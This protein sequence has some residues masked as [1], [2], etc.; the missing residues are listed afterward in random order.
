LM[1][2]INKSALY[3]FKDGIGQLTDALVKDLR[4]RSNVELK[5]GSRVS[6]LKF[7]D[8]NEVEITTS[9]GKF[10]GD[11]VISTIPTYEL[12][13]LLPTLPHLEY[14]PF[15]TVGVVNVAY[16]QRNLLPIRGFGFLVPQ[17]TPNNHY[18]VL[19]I[20]FDSDAMP[21]QDHPNDN[22]TKVT[23]MLGGHYYDSLEEEEFPN[24]EELLCQALQ[25][26]EN[27]LGIY[28][29]PAEYVAK[30]QRKC[31]PQYYVNHHSRLKELHN[32]IKENFKN[33][34]SVCGSSYWGV[35]INDC[36]VNSARLALNL[37]EDKP[38]GVV[39]T[40]LERV[41]KA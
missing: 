39:V 32:A 1:N 35:S 27:T 38:P 23:V 10:K 3:S 9:S 24:E 19:G 20:I 37:L 12:A 5:A 30:L 36:A 16:A 26:I 15:V 7:G 2:I 34:L 8:A 28:A 29:T 40:G 33:K 21:S 31:I 4:N 11:H 18:H 17:A 25:T 41:E 13:K 6:E 22:Y 14:N